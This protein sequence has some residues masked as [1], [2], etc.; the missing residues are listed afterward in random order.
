MLS[1]VGRVVLSVDT[2]VETK[3]AFKLAKT[4]GL[5]STMHGKFL[6]VFRFAIHHN[7]YRHTGVQRNTEL[8]ATLKQK[9]GELVTTVSPLKCA[10]GA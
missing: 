1:S 9:L 7:L 2:V 5:C 3:L 6:V 8:V 4:T 10:F